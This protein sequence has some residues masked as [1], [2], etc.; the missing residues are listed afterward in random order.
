MRPPLISTDMRQ[1]PLVRSDRL[2]TRS[3]GAA[4]IDRAVDPEPDGETVHPAAFVREAREPCRHPAG[5]A[6]PRGGKGGVEPADR[7]P[8]EREQARKR[9]LEAGRRRDRA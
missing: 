5:V 9:E 6:A 7:A 4:S 1:N 8:V 2:Y 3:R